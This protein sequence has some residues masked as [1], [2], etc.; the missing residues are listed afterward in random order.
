MACA[1][2][3]AAAHFYEGLAYLFQDHPEISE[4]WRT[5]M[6]DELAHERQLSEIK[7]GLS[8][9]QLSKAAEKEIAR[10]LERE[11]AKFIPK[12]DLTT[13]E[14]LD[15]AYEVA[16]DLEYSEINSVYKAIVNKCVSEVDRVEFVLAQNL[17]HVSRLET[18]SKSVADEA[19][20]R[21]IIA[22]Q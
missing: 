18:F 21:S 12:F 6:K 13:I 2:E 10:E 19:R 9:N 22:H 17:K 1:T 5:M 4:F 20:R 16:Y 14:T 8:A 3:R 7:R 11:V 15:D